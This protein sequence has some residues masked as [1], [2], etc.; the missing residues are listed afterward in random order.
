MVSC[1]RIS[2]ADLNSSFI[3]RLNCAQGSVDA[4]YAASY[5]EGN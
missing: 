5:H 4:E 1:S 2:K 3:G